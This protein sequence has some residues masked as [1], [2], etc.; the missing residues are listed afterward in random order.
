MSF[1][2]LNRDIEEVVIIDL[3][4]E[5]ERNDWRISE[6][7]RTHLAGL[8]VPQF[9]LSCYSKKHVFEALDW[10]L[11]RLKKTNF[12]LHFSA[13]GNTDGIGLKATNE[14]IAWS[15]L[16]GGLR[17]INHQ[18]NGDLI[19]NMIACQG[20][21]GVKIQD[22]QDPHE[23]FFGLVGP[24]IKIAVDVAKV[25][26]NNFYEK[27]LAG[28]EI[29]IIVGDINQAQGSSVLWCQSSQLRRSKSSSLS[30]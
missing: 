6:D 17:K 10:C 19:V 25:V 5:K 20:I 23:P 15:E 29:P 22:L 7:L 4:P 3:L 9:Q 27:M 16:S 26:S 12:V 1:R 21:Y 18:M 30:V 2:A 11:A 24:T 14:F 8:G 13:H 28:S